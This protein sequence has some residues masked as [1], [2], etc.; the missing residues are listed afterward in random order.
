MCINAYMHSCFDSLRFLKGDQRSC[1]REWRGGLKFSNSFK[2]VFASELKFVS[3]LQISQAAFLLCRQA[4][5]G[6]A[7]RHMHMCTHTCT[8]GSVGVKLT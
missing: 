6:S 4:G 8:Q 3:V 1:G 5:V 2:W 7:H